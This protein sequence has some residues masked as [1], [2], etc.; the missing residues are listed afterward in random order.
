VK[1]YEAVE[2]E[3][4]DSFLISET[5]KA[6]WFFDECIEYE[7]WGVFVADPTPQYPCGW[8]FSFSETFSDGNTN[9]SWTSPKVAARN[10]KVHGLSIPPIN[11][12]PIDPYE[13]RF[14]LYARDTQPNNTA[15][16]RTWYF[17]PSM[18]DDPIVRPIGDAAPANCTDKMRS[19][20]NG[21]DCREAINILFNKN[22]WTNPF[23]FPAGSCI[24]GKTPGNT[25]TA[26]ICNFHSEERGSRYDTRQLIDKMMAVHW[27]CSEWYGK[28]SSWTFEQTQLTL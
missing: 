21:T 18:L 3:S 8:N 10:H 2:K 6:T 19:D 27:N 5:V 22:L 24:D 7:F 14:K 4:F 12:S 13:E 9:E 23:D 25:C 11:S 15:G 20:F 16:N 1:S 17:R 26:T 28:G